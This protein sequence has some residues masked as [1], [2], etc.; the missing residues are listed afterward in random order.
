MASSTTTSSNP[1]RETETEALDREAGEERTRHINKGEILSDE[2]Y[3]DDPEESDAETEQDE[4]RQKGGASGGKKRTR[5]SSKRKHGRG[6]KR[7]RKDEESES[8]ATK[9]GKKKDDKKSKKP[10]VDDKGDDKAKRDR[11]KE[12]EFDQLILV[13]ESGR[14]EPIYRAAAE[15][16]IRSTYIEHGGTTINPA[17]PLPVDLSKY[18]LKQLAHV[19][20]NMRRFISDNAKSEVVTKALNA[21]CNLSYIG[22]KLF[23]LPLD[24]SL[25]SSIHSDN[26]LRTALVETFVGRTSS[27]HP[28]LALLIATANHGSNLAVQYI[29]KCMDSGGAGR[30]ENV[31]S[32]NNA[33]N[34]S[35]STSGITVSHV[36]VVQRS[37][38]GSRK[39]GGIFVSGGP[40]PQ[41]SSN[42][43]NKTS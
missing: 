10:V 5:P 37:T 34:G 17:D 16:W 14:E 39:E 2:E 1:R 22:T 13:L 7:A 43:A 26:M 38:E 29:D 4:R 9:K 31:A 40:P 6:R 36:P 24:K 35:G 28:I 32:S 20:M 33:R 30:E 11:E 21:M 12:E 19:M 15:Q 42:Q 18:N 25:F 23:G 41:T 27:L 8:E 3:S